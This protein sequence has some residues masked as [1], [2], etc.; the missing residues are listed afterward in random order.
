MSK[1]LS[2][3]N[4]VYKFSKLKYILNAS[5]IGYHTMDK[6]KR[7][8]CVIINEDELRHEMRDNNSSFRFLMK[9]MSKRLKLKSLKT[10][11]SYLQLY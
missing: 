1:K 11:K 5:N 8:E 7:I 3:A 2:V 10:K 6:Y 4:I 9:K